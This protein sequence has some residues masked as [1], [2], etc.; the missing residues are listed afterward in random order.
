LLET[1]LAKRIVAGVI[2][3]AADDVV[4]KVIDEVIVEIVENASN[5]Q[6][7]PVV[8]DVIALGMILKQDSHH[9]RGSGC[10]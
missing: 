4:A 7:I 9:R 3:K 5:M 2:A 8:N 6:E 1:H 10:R